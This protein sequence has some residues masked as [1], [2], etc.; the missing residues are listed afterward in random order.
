MSIDMS[1]KS[2]GVTQEVLDPTVDHMAELA[3]EDQCTKQM[4]IS[5]LK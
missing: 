5:E 4:L 1:L 3:I 2:Q